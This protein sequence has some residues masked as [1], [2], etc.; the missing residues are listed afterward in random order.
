MKKGQNPC[1]VICACKLARKVL[2]AYFCQGTHLFLEKPDTNC[3]AL[4]E[5]PWQT[6]VVMGCW[7][8]LKDFLD[9]HQQMQQFING[10][11]YL[12]EVHDRLTEQN[13]MAA[14]H[15]HFMALITY[16]IFQ[17][18]LVEAQSRCSFYSMSQHSL[19]NAPFPL[20]DGSTAFSSC[21]LWAGRY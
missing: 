14:M 18:Q 15:G 19:A 7:F 12:V 9:P 3:L 5:K 17:Q 11:I 16:A 1:I 10:Q 2:I 4:P 6:H 21:P 13:C 20:H 8:I